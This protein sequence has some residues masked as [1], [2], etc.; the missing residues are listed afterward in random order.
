[1]G[2]LTDLAKPFAPHLVKRP[3]QGKYGDYVAH[4]EVTQK[5]LAV[6]GPY[7]FEVT[8]LLREQTSKV[9]HPIIVGCIGR[10]T[11]VVDGREVS[12]SEVGDCENPHVKN[13]DGER[14]KDAASDAIKRCA[15]RLGVGLHLWAAENYF[16]H[17]YLLSL[18]P[19]QEAPDA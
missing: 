17:G 8:Q 1:M 16:L 6:L 9:D 12:V 18:E 11:C 19:E 13:S 2:Q 10:L 3:P 5:L 7:S 15:M 4:S 14:A